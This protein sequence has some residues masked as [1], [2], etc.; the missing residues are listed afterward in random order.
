MSTPGV[1]LYQISC[2][3]HEHEIQLE[4]FSAKAI[5]ALPPEG[6]E[7]TIPSTEV[8]R[9]RDLRTTHRIFSVDPPGCQDIDDTMH[10]KMLPNGDIEVGVHIADV[11][12]FV[13]HNSSLDKEAQVRGTTFYLVDRRFDM[14]PSLLSSDLCSLHGN[15]DRLAVSVIWTMSSDLKVVKSCWYGRTV[16]HNCQAMTYEQAHN[17]L[18]DKPP[19]DPSKPPPPPLTAGAPVDPSQIQSLKTD[20]VILQRLARKLRKDR[21]EI[22]GAVD[23]SSGDLGTELKFVLDENG[24]P[25]KITPKKEMEIH[26]TIAEMMILANQNVASKIYGS[27][28]DSSL[29]R[30][31]RAVA[32]DRFEELESALKAAGI[33]FDGSSNMA[34]AESLKKAKQEGK[35]NKL[36]NSL[37]R[38]L[39]TRYVFVQLLGSNVVLCTHCF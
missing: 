31:H 2:L 37:W 7:W 9:R 20:L 14:L 33:S 12:Y 32:K 19:D 11:T 16:I 24:N 10:A 3:L 29:L 26:H 15:T 1:F 21:E 30:I 13:P 36:V 39:A 17:I 34:L 27:F 18:H 22:G 25:I 6:S 28:P 8:E 35:G 5:A 4:P 23:L 38:S